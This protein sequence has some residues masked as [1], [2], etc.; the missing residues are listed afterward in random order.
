MLRC[1]H[2]VRRAVNRV[3]TSGKDTYLALPAICVTRSERQFG[4]FRLSDPIVLRRLCRFR[5]IDVI[6]ILQ[7]SWRVL[8]DA[9]E[10]L[11]EQP[12]LDGRLAALAQSPDYL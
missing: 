11:F 5:P 3:R 2:H 10:P 7:Q 8:A 12:L 6:E 4:S 1:E 9:K